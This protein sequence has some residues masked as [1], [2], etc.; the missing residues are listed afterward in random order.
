MTHKRSWWQQDSPKLLTSAG[1][2]PRRDIVIDNVQIAARSSAFMVQGAG[3]VIRNC[4]INSDVNSALWVH[5]PG[6]HIENN[7]IIVDCQRGVRESCKPADAPIRLRMGDGA[8]IRNNVIVLP[9]ATH[10]RIVRVFDTARSVTLEGNTFIRLNKLEDA[11]SVQSGS[12]PQL[13][14]RNNR[15]DNGIVIKLWSRYARRQR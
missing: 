7:L 12:S 6:A 14:A 5:G 4:V 11:V 2:D 1:R 8:V 10:Q 3:T 15:L 9:G 13:T